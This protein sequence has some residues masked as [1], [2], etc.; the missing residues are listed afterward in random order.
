M[1]C[2]AAPPAGIYPAGVF[3][4]AGLITVPEAPE[5]PR[6]TDMFPDATVYLREANLA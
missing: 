6:H 2:A 5:A 1:G 4:T 3:A